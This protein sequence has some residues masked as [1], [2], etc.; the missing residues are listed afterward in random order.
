[1][2]RPGAAVG[3]VNFGPFLEEFEDDGGAAQRDQKAD[4]NRLAHG[5]AELQGQ[6]QPGQAGGRHLYRPG[7]QHRLP[8]LEKIG[9][10]KFHPDSE[11]Q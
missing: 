11:E 8:D 6:N 10:G 5:L 2:P 1:M 7:H 3:G 9:E 4:E